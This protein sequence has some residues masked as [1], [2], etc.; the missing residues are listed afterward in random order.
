M[1]YLRKFFSKLVNEMV[2][3]DPAMKVPNGTLAFKY[4]R[5][6]VVARA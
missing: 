6:N 1:R 4:A 2:T 3:R 5:L